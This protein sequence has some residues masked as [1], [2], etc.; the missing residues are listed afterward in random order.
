VAGQ[1]G[2]VVVVV[3]AGAAPTQLV[4][5]VDAAAQVVV[6]VPKDPHGT[7]VVEQVPVDT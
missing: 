4:A 7:P 1:E 6:K 5:L 3:V 2:E